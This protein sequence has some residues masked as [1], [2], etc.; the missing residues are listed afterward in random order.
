M[1]ESSLLAL[2]QNLDCQPGWKY[3]GIY[4]ASLKC[5]DFTASLWPGRY[6]DRPIY[7]ADPMVSFSDDI[8]EKEQ[9]RARKA[10][11]NALAEAKRKRQAEEAQGLREEKAK[12]KVFK[13]QV[14]FVRRLI[15]NTPRETAAMEP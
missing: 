1:L 3:R 10:H 7:Q 12:R 11:I 15:Y 14:G 6:E 2:R 4:S 5:S 8:A 9:E 13:P